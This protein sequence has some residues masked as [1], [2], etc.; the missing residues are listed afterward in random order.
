MQPC[1]H[2][3]WLPAPLWPRAQGGQAEKLARRFAAAGSA[4]IVGGRRT[5]LLDQLAAEGFSRPFPST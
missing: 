2:T 5:D 1:G 3:F 4:V